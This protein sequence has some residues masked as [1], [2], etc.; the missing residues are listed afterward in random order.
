MTRTL[1]LLALVGLFLFISPSCST[2]DGSDAVIKEGEI[3]GNDGWMEDLK[4]VVEDFGA[5]LDIPKD[6]CTP[7]CEGKVCGDNGCGGN[8]GEC[9]AGAKCTDSGQCQ[10]D[11]ESL[12]ANRQCGP[13]GSNQ[14]CDCGEC[15]A[16]LSC[17]NG[18]CLVNCDDVCALGECTPQWAEGTCNCGSCNDNNAC[19]DD[20]CTDEAKCVFTA[21]NGAQCND[22]DPCT[23]D[24]TCVEDQCV[25]MEADCECLVDDDCTPL[26]DDDLCNGTL[27]CDT[28]ASNP[29][30]VLWTNPPS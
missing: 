9:D 10:A 5:E 25:G 12:C 3:V 26:E 17:I 14:E 11:C 7:N 18:Q 16:G 8:C 20:T 29:A 19:T 4:D 2:T 30:S 21:T 13:A 24:D 28:T 23:T 6:S 22:Q 15:D 1:W 27:Y